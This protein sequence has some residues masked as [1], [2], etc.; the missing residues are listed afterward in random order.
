MAI[1]TKVLV[2]GLRYNGDRLI[3]DRVVCGT[4][5]FHRFAHGTTERTAEL[6]VSKKISEA[7]SHKYIPES[8]SCSL[9]VRQVLN[10]YW[11]EHL[12]SITSAYREIRKYHLDRMDE[13][14]GNF[15]IPAVSPM[16]GQ[17]SPRILTASQVDRYIADRS[18]D[19]NKHGGKISPGYIQDEINV[20]V[21]AI[22]HCMGRSGLVRISYNP[23][24]G[25]ARPKQKDTSPIVLD[26]GVEDGAQWRAIYYKSTLAVK[27]LV[28]TLYE[29]GM[30]P[31][32]VFAMRRSWWI[33]CSPDRWVIMFPPEFVEK[34]LKERR[35]PVSLALLE[36]MRPRLQTMVPDDLFFPSPKAGA[37]RTNSWQGF[38]N[39]VKRVR[40]MATGASK[41]SDYSEFVAWARKASWQQDDIS[42]AWE[43]RGFNGKVVTPYALRRTRI[44]IWDA[45]DENAS[46]YVSGHKLKKDCH[47]T[48]YVRFP[49]QRLF[50]LVGLDYNKADLRLI[51]SA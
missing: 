4:R 28:L 12:S 37:I 14:F 29:T 22:N 35:V 47:N 31:K 42:V 23:I 24:K 32:E 30:R 33:E 15:I 20:L 45:I 41:F 10:A 7:V 8:K 50:R 1:K 51:K 43:V 48:H 49:L 11:Q 44:S 46:R 5:I 18:K 3:F 16:H 36:M 26:E 19:D 40:S 39:A 2:R 13:F 38:E 21:Q 25:Y 6:W 34:S 17:V 27:P 9:T